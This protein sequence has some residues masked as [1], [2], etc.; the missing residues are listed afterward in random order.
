MLHNDNLSPSTIQQWQK[1]N[2]FTRPTKRKLKKAT[3]MCAQVK[4]QNCYALCHGMNLIQMLILLSFFTFDNSKKYKKK[5]LQQ[6]YILSPSYKNDQMCATML[7]LHTKSHH[8]KKILS[9]SAFLVLCA[10]IIEIE[11][12]FSYYCC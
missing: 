9:L 8:D 5:M 6:R 12:P 11:C 7:V 4:H 1:I 3:T 10:Q 2:S